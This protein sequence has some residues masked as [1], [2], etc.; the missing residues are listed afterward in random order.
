MKSKAG[1][2]TTGWLLSEV[3][4]KVSED[5]IWYDA[6]CKT[7]QAITTLESRKEDGSPGL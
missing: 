5:E 3:I 7:K 2:I 4:R 6:F 1:Q